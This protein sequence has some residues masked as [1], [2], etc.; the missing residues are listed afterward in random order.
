MLENVLRTFLGPIDCCFF[1]VLDNPRKIV[2]FLEKNWSNKFGN[3]R[4]SWF[5]IS[6]TEAEH[7]Q[8]QIMNKEGIPDCPEAVF[9]QIRKIY[10]YSK[11]IIG[12]S[13]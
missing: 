6:C 10:S 2:F 5:W 1:V 13:R 11:L 12:G 8:I 3:K 4:T 7:P 9:L